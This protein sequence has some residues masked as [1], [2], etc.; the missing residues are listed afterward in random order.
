[1]IVEC[2]T[3]TSKK[4]EWTLSSV[5]VKQPLPGRWSQIGDTFT[6]H[7]PVQPLSGL[8]NSFSGE[9]VASVNNLNKSNAIVFN[10][11]HE[12]LRLTPR[13]RDQIQPLDLPWL[14]CERKPYE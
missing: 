14:R 12:R 6:P 8:R 4:P 2:E 5:S 11:L 1:V 13:Q 3:S 9:L 7:F 10:H